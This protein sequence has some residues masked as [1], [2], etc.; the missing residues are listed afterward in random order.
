MHTRACGCGVLTHGGGAH[1]P[2]I[3][4][5]KFA[6]H[7]IAI[8]RGPGSWGATLLR[9]GDTRALV[10]KGSCGG[11]ANIPCPT[12]T[13]LALPLHFLL[14]KLSPSGD[15]LPRV[16]YKWPRSCGFPCGLCTLV[17]VGWLGV[18]SVWNLWGVGFSGF[19][20]WLNFSARWSL[21]VRP[22]SPSPTRGPDSF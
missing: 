13:L 15:G 20:Y 10:T 4:L 2:P 8:P 5:H 17:L 6:I 19:S 3:T 14:A 21:A 16:L 12:V 22:L 11:G 9:S 7:C 1:E 18:F